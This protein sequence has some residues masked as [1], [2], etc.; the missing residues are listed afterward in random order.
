MQDLGAAEVID[1][2]ELTSPARPLARER[3]AGGI[4]S[5]GSTTLANLLSMTKCR[6]AIAACGLAGRHGLGTSQNR[7]PTD[8]DPAK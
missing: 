5:V 2:N 6:G 8:T 7:Y 4:D 1:R 3:W